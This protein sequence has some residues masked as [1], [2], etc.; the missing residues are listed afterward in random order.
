MRSGCPI[1]EVAV[2]M[3]IFLGF[4]NRRREDLGLQNLISQHLFLGRMEKKYD[5]L[6]EALGR[7]DG[8]DT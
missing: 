5:L 4:V 6:H 2:V 7:S 3:R 1:C 8:M